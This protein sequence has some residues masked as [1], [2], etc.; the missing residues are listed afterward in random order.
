MGL[1]EKVAFKQRPEG[2]EGQARG[3]ASRPREPGAEGTGSKQKRPVDKERIEGE[4][5]GC[6]RMDGARVLIWSGSYCN[7]EQKCQTT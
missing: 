4:D 6:E 2:G 3:G 7:Y 5:R 1:S